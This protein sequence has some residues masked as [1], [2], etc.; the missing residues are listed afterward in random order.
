MARIIGLLALA[1]ALSACSAIKLGYNN[2]SELVY[3][4]LDGYLDFTDEQ[5]P[6]VREDLARLHQWHRANELPRYA[7]LL[8]EVERLMPGDVS[9][10]Q[11][12]AIAGEVVQRLT[13]LSQR[14]EPAVVTTAMGLSPEQLQHLARRYERNNTDYRKDWLSLDP[15]AQREKRFK[16]LLER[17][18]MVYGSLGDPQQDVLRQQVAQSVFDARQFDAER[19]RRQRDAL[20]TLR[21]LQQPPMPLGSAV[22]AMRG[23]LQRSRE[24]PDPV[25][26]QQQER[27]LQEGCRTFAALHNSTTAAQRDSAVRRLR[28][29]QRD[30]GELAA[31]R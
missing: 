9:A 14:A 23:Y 11:V 20:Q 3:W 21:S 16:V 13:A 19:Q 5:S 12:C 18:E 10:Q 22:L 15:Q 6:R 31:A 29:Y 27:L 25:W 30:L 28:A 17:S 26:R 4:W 8:R 2:A 7:A 1:A 24:S